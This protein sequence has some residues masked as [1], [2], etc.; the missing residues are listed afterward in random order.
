MRQGMTSSE[1]SIARLDLCALQTAK[2]VRSA[3]NHPESTHSIGTDLA[4]LTHLEL[5]Q[6]RNV[7]FVGLELPAHH[8]TTL[9]ATNQEIPLKSVAAKGGGWDARNEP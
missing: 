2:C 8:H 3:S 1:P 5:E 7:R 4:L 9:A 6:E